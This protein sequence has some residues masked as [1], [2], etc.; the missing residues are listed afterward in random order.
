MLTLHNSSVDV[1]TIS[2]TTTLGKINKCQVFAEFDVN[3]TS[4]GKMESCTDDGVLS[5][6][7]FN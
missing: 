7:V 3:H 2:V 6:I 5:E 4:S 1:F